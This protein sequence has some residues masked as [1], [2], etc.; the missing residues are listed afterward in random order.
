VETVK[1]EGVILR[2]YPLAEKD[3]IISV[4]TRLLGKI[5]GVVPRAAQPTSHYWGKLESFGLVELVFLLHAQ[6]ALVKVQSVELICAFGARLP[7]YGNFLQLSLIAEILIE[8]SPEREPNDDLYRLLM[9]VLP[10]FKDRDS[11]PLA[12]LYFKIWYLKIAG[13][14]PATRAC[15]K[16]AK[17]LAGAE[18][19]FI[20]GGLTG[21]V[22]GVCRV[23]L[24]QRVSQSAYRLLGAIRRHSL[25][26]LQSESLDSGSITELSWIAEA[27]LERNFERHFRSLQLLR[28]EGA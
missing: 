26:D 4:Y 28:S 18:D 27:M 7:S 25:N 14:L 10:R 3:R 5:S 15:Q 6:R 9:L 17:I 11:G 13:L 12:A 1:T 20:V 24:D 23:S 8:T 22:C 2:A 16:C 19:V 21:L